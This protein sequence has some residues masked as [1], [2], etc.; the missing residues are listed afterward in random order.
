MSTPAPPMGLII[1]LT[2]RCPLQCAYCSNPLALDAP[3]SELS[4]DDWFRVL[5]QA[6]A[7][8]SLQVHFSGGEPMARRD[9]AQLVAH[10]SAAGLIPTS[11]H[12]ACC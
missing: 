5:D 10:A 12:R 7:I 6:A 1:E 4:T 3:K 11:S 8:G 2:H 9:L